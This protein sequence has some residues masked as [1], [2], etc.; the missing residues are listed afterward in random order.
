[1]RRVLVCLLALFLSSCGNSWFHLNDSE[2]RITRKTDSDVVTYD[3]K[4][5]LNGERTI[6]GVLY[7]N[8]VVI[9]ADGQ[10]DCFNQRYKNPARIRYEKAGGALIEAIESADPEW[11]PTNMPRDGEICEHAGYKSWDPKKYG[12]KAVF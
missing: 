3:E 6:K 8:I 5:A 1:M 11:Q 2:I 12:D 7:N 9:Y 4:F 10:I